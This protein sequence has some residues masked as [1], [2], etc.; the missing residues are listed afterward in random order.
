[1]APPR[2]LSKEEL[3]QKRQLGMVIMHVLKEGVEETVAVLS[4]RYDQRRSLVKGR[5]REG[6]LTTM[7]EV[8]RES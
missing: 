4:A 7:A 1:V 5:K 2:K 6:A 8:S 3:K